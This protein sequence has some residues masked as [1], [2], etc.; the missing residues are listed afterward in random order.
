MPRPLLQRSCRDHQ[1]H[2]PGHP[3]VHSSWWGALEHLPAAAVQ[4]GADR[5]SAAGRRRRLHPHQPFL[6]FCQRRGQLQCDGQSQAG[7]YLRHHKHCGEERWCAHEHHR[8]PGHLHLAP[9]PVSASCGCC[10]CC[11]CCRRGLLR[12]AGLHASLGW[13]A[14]VCL[15][16]HLLCA[17][18]PWLLPYCPPP[19]TR[20]KPI[21]TA[22]N[23]GGNSYDVTITP[24][25]ATPLKS[26]PAGGWTYYSIATEAG[27]PPPSNQGFICA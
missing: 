1:H 4:A 12:L 15:P 18:G 20:S 7:H 10:A 6:P 23:K 14:R 8:T 5:P 16:P 17:G 22:A 21:V 19:S 3:A 25:T 26:Y 24:A 27:S 2:Q 13:P 11:A 9:L